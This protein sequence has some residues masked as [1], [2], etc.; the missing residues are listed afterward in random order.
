[1]FAE[2]NMVT[3][4]GSNETNVVFVNNVVIVIQPPSCIHKCGPP[5]GWSWQ[6]WYGARR[7]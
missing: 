7:V 6:F 3:V 2:H 5:V 4:I 1:M